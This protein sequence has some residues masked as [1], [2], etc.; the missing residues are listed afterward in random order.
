M[1]Y[2]HPGQAKSMPIASRHPML[3]HA[4]HRLETLAARLADELRQRPGAP[5][6]ARAYRRP[7]SDLGAMAAAATRHPTWYRST[8]AHRAPGR[9]RLGGHARGGAYAVRGAGVRTGVSALAYFRTFGP[10]GQRRRDCA[11]LG[12]RR[13]PQ[14]VRARGPAGD[15]VRPLPRLPARQHPGMAGGRVVAMARAALGGVG[16]RP[17]AGAAVEEP[18][19]DRRP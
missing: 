3:I 12:G 4:S 8:P 2:T 1:S 11:L 10:L 19:L 18:A 9:V 14:A 16:S 17:S 6:L 15:R 7:A 5:L 13:F